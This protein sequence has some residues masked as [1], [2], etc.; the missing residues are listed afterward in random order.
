MES[1]TLHTLLAAV[2]FATVKHEGQKRGDG[3][4]PY[5]SHLTRVTLVLAC[6]FGMTDPLLLSASMLHDVLEDTDTDYEEIATEFGPWVADAV[7]ALTKNVLLPK[8]DREQDYLRRLLE[9]PENVRILK[10]A[11]M[12]DNMTSRK[13]TPRVTK[14]VENLR[15]I[16]EGFSTSFATPEG[17]AAY[18]KVAALHAE[19]VAQ[20]AAK[21]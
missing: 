5:V 1:K 4:T 12:F 21:S 13:G 11:D 2:R 19:C 8:K 6:E 9:A 20:L 15:P 18:A 16:I 14:T 7:V 17:Q 3:E 10:L